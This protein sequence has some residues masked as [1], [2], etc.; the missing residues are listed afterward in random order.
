MTNDQYGRFVLRGIRRVGRQCCGVFVS[1][2]TLGVFIA[3][4]AIPYKTPWLMLKFIVRHHFLL[5]K[6]FQDMCAVAARAQE[7]RVL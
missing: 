1:L 2:W 6:V 4:S 3:Y 7:W 5:I